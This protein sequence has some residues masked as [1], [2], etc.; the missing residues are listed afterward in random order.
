MSSFTADGEEPIGFSVPHIDDS[1][2]EAVVAVLRGGWLTTGK[3]CA[4]LERELE[5]YLGVPHAV[6]MSSCTAAIETAFAS[7]GLPAGAR[8][9]VPTWTFPSSALAPAHQ[10][11]VP[12]LVDVDPDTLNVSADAVGTAIDTGV[13]VFVGVHFGGVPLDREVHEVLRGSGISL[14][15]DAA[16]AMGT[17]DHRG[18]AAGQ[19]NVAACFSFYATKNL[20]SGEGGALV[21]EDGDL[22]AFARSYRLHGMA[23][24]AWDRYRTGSFGLP[25]VV[26]P[27]IKGNLPDLLAA[28]ARSQLRRFDQLQKLRREIVLQYRAR[29]GYVDGLRCAP[30]QLVDGSAD[31]LMVVVLDEGI[32]RERV[33]AELSRASIGSSVHFRPLHH[34]AWFRRHAVLPPAGLPVADE[35]APRVL[36]LPLHCRLQPG[37]VDRICDVLASAIAVSRAGARRRGVTL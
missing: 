32:D 36:S 29:L 11:A 2:V 3:E 26:A 18:R 1:D 6:A 28:L 21:T 22:A 4:A 35:L 33:V 14:I 27:G 19:A 9:G 20:T 34:L 30:T 16:H 25:E 23:G 15:E 37:H 24:D 31:H 8:V 13:D 12:V 7:L 5:N 17:S 10:G